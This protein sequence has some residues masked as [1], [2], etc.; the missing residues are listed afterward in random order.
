MPFSVVHLW[1][2]NV[3]SLQILFILTHFSTDEIAEIFN[4]QIRPSIN[5]LRNFDIS[6]DQIYV[7]VRDEIR[8]LRSTSQGN[9][10]LL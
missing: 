1:K 9:L 7:Q 8:R 10:I 5:L 2:T 3:Y 6:L 4:E